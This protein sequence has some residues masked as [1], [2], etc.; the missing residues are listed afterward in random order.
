LT[1]HVVDGQPGPAISAGWVALA[2]A[3]S[4]LP[5]RLGSLLQCCM[6]EPIQTMHA[7]RGTV[8]VADE[9]TT[10]VHTFGRGEHCQCQSREHSFLLVYV[11]WFR[12]TMRGSYA[13]EPERALMDRRFSPVR[14]VSSRGW[15]HAGLEGPGAGR[16]DDID[17]CGALS[18]LQRRSAQTPP[19]PLP[20][21]R[22]LLLGT[23]V[24]VR[25]A[26]ARVPCLRL[27]LRGRRQRVRASACMH[28]GVGWAV[29]DTLHG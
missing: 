1:G 11:T 25:G 18:R 15:S 16:D 22:L 20:V 10:D 8:A 3:C 7:T 5:G 23:V 2:V 27:R 12:N 19:L 28:G 9:R 13:G 24:A 17:T 4:L 6:H 26:P 21:P 29:G 14:L